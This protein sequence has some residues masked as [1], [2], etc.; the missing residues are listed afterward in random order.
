[1]NTAIKSPALLNVFTILLLAAIVALSTSAITRH[2][3]TSS[4]SLVGM[5][6]LPYAALAF[7]LLAPACAYASRPAYHFDERSRAMLRNQFLRA[8]GLAVIVI[9]SL[10]LTGCASVK[11]YEETHDEACLVGCAAAQAPVCKAKYEKSQDPAIVA[12]CIGESIMK[13]SKA[14]YVAPTTYSV[15]P[16]SAPEPVPPPA[17]PGENTANDSTAPVQ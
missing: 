2:L 11:A 6:Y 9:V 15:L 7:I 1:M 12:G 14:C 17:A 13:C 4:D 5:V 3:V 8:A 16:P 10:L